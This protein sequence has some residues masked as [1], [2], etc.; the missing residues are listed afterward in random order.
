MTWKRTKLIEIMTSPN[1]VVTSRNSLNRLALPDF[2]P[3]TKWNLLDHF[4]CR[5]R[6]FGLSSSSS[7]LV[8]DWVAIFADVCCVAILFD[9]ISFELNWTKINQNLVCLAFIEKRISITFSWILIKRR[10]HILFAREEACSFFWHPYVI[11]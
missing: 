5:S 3:S 11:K 8:G 1:S 2:C 6:R 4:F 10:F 7:I 9:E